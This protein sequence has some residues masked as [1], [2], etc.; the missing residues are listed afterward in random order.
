MTVER[1]NHV[2]TYNNKVNR[3]FTEIMDRSSILMD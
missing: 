3:C 2:T 1:L